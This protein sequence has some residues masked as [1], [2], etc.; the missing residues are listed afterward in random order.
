VSSPITLAP[1]D[2]QPINAFIIS[3]IQAYG[4]TAPPITSAN[5][6]K[7]VPPAI[8]TALIA[9]F[10]A[11][12]PAAQNFVQNL[13]QAELAALYSVLAALLIDGVPLGAVINSGIL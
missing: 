1:G 6:D 9:Q 8:G 10:K 3:Y 7:N 12:T 11:L 13:T 5:L 2:L 4:R